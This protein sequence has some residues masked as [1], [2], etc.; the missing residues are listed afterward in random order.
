[1][2]HEAEVR[3]NGE[4]TLTPRMVSSLLNVNVLLKNEDIHT[5]EVEV[6]QSPVLTAVLIVVSAVTLAL[7]SGAVLLY[8]NE[9]G[10]FD[11]PTATARVSST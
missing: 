11:K 2:L 7:V 1:M 6:E 4:H 10:P 3:M 9:I 8:V 5:N